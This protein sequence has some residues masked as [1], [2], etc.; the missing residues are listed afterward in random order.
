MLK[1]HDIFNHATYQLML[2]DE[3][4]IRRIRYLESLERQ[5]LLLL[6]IP[7]SSD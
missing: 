7:I 3:P 5:I 6:I 1:L 4:S 2:L